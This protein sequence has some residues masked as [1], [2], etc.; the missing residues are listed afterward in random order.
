MPD[1]FRRLSF[2]GPELQRAVNAASKSPDSMLPDGEVVGIESKQRNESHWF[3]VT[4]VDDI[5]QKESIKQVRRDAALFSIIDHCL[6]VG[7]PLPRVA[8]KT[9]RVVDGRL[10][11]D[12]AVGEPVEV[13]T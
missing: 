8:R 11:L 7:I 1:E 10:C 12:I 13:F 6:G 5:S 4:I 2:T 9:L 3:E